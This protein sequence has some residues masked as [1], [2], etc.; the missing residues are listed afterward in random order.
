MLLAATD[1]PA[2]AAL[3]SRNFRRE[4]LLFVMASPGVMF[5][6]CRC[7]SLS[8][9]RHKQYPLRWSIATRFDNSSHGG[10]A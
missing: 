1:P 5:S 2:A 7:V 4:R 6:A 9:I 3:I 8:F 10:F